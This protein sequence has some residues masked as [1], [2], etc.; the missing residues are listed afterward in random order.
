VIL[1]PVPVALTQRWCPM[2][3]KAYHGT[4][5]TERR[6]DEIQSVQYS[7]CPECGTVSHSRVEPGLSY[8][9]AFARV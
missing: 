8:A 5:L 9:A 4:V 3:D 6:D 7:P 2:C 1:P